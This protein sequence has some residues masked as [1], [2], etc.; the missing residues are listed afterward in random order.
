MK[1]MKWLMKLISHLDSTI[2]D[3]DIKLLELLWWCS[4]EKQKKKEEYENI[5]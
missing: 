1:K 3:Q 4:K 5:R 2:N